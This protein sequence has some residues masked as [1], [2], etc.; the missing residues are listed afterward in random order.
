[1]GNQEHQLQC[2]LPDAAMQFNTGKAEPLVVHIASDQDITVNALEFATQSAE[3]TYILPVNA[4]GTSYLA[5]TYPGLRHAFV[6][7]VTTDANSTT[8]ISVTTLVQ[9]DFGPPGT[10]NITMNALE[11]FLLYSSD[12]TLDL[13]GTLVTGSAP[14]ALYVGNQCTNVPSGCIACDIVWEQLPPTNTW[15]TKFLMDALPILFTDNVTCAVDARYDVKGDLVRIM[16]SQDGTTL[17][18]NGASTGPV[19]GD[20]TQW[21]LP[22]LNRGEVFQFMLPQDTPGYITASKPVS[23]MQMM[24]GQGAHGSPSDP[25]ML[26][27]SKAG[28]NMTLQHRMS[29]LCSMWF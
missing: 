5:H 22:M 2:F 7:I 26:G 1:M 20:G 19:S 12:V 9:T 11:A 16:A 29:S 25:A 18:F 21:Q 13:S 10:Y 14:F 4:L 27:E 8:D 24:T 6:Q 17:S 3:G 23:I 15:G 28:M